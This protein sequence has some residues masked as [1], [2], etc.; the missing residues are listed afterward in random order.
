MLI[1][2]VHGTAR[3][4]VTSHSI[5]QS[6]PTPRLLGPNALRC[7]LPRPDRG[8]SRHESDQRPRAVGRRHVHCVL[9]VLVDLHGVA[10]TGWLA[11]L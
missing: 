6:L 9:G 11:I 5:R 4:P 10:D 3:R 2:R 1:S 8:D 7:Q